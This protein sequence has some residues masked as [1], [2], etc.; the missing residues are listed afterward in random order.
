M[1]SQNL[2]FEQLYDL[3]A[4]RIII[5]RVEDCYAALGI[6]HQIYK[7]IQE[8]FKDYIATPKSNGYQSIHT[9]VVGID[10]RPVEIQIRTKEMDRSAEIGIAAHWN[11]KEGTTKENDSDIDRHVNWLRDLVEVLKSEDKDPEEFLKLLK[12]DLFKDEIFVFTPNGDLVQLQ[13]GSTYQA[14]WAPVYCSPGSAAF[15][16]WHG[17]WR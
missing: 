15:A 7:P 3:F 16:A 2:E 4:I 9:T 11:Y 13:N 8:R 1:L 10:G 6:V 14:L 12:L 17:F 5:E